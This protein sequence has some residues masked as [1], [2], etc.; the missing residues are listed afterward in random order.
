MRSRRSRSIFGIDVA[1]FGA[2]V[3]GVA[4][5]ARITDVNVTIVTPKHRVVRK[6]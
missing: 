5:V 3:G 6:Q 2:G 1:A 4:G